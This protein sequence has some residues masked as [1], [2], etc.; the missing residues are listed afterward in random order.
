[1]HE[2]RDWESEAEMMIEEALGS[3]EVSVDQLEAL[4]QVGEE[5]KES[6]REMNSWVDRVERLLSDRFHVA[7]IAAGVIIAA[8]LVGYIRGWWQARRLDL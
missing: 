1:M 2:N 3:L 8:S 6:L 5:F 4:V 7:L